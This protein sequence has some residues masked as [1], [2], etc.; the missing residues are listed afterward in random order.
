MG[1]HFRSNWSKCHAR[2]IHRC[3]LNEKRLSPK[4]SESKSGR[5]SWVRYFLENA[6]RPGVKILS[7]FLT[8]NAVIICL[9][10]K[11]VPPLSIISSQFAPDVIY[12]CQ[13]A[14]HFKNGL[15]NS[16]R[17]LPLMLCPLSAQIAGDVD[18]RFSKHIIENDDD[19]A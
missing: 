9:N 7:L 17:F 14:T 1:S 13:I 4:L 11:V 19:E 8:F 10:Q 6:R 5:A 16:E 18:A 2:S 15:P 3:P 12:L